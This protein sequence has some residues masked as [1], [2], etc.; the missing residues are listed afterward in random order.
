MAR[1]KHAGRRLSSPRQN[2]RARNAATPSCAAANR[3]V[4][5]IHG[6]AQRNRGRFGT[7]GSL[8]LNWH[9]TR[10]RGPAR[11]ERPADRRPANHPG[12]YPAA[13][14]PPRNPVRRRQDGL[15]PVGPVRRHRP[16]RRAVPRRRRLLAPLD[17][18]HSGPGPD[19]SRPR[20][21]PSR[22]R[23]IRFPARRRRRLR[24]RHHRRRR[25]RC[26]VGAETSY[27]VVGFSFGGTMAACVGA[28]RGKR[29]RSVTIIGS[30]GVGALGP[31]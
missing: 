1:H 29:V 16:R 15:A 26:I 25:D 22:P 27:D 7:G 19:L 14:H 28:L 8:Y 13:G 6:P 12:P 23:R 17:P 10:T 3:V 11:D 18:H 31:R 20:P 2:R 4:A 30:S 9:P 21:R 5:A 24:H